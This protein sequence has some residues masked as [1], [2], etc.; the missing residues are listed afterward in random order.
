MNTFRQLSIM[1]FALMCLALFALPVEATEITVASQQVTG[2]QVSASTVKLRIYASESFITSDDKII[3]GGAPPSGKFYKELTCTVAGGVITIPQFV[4]DSTTDNRSHVVPTYTA[5]FFN[6]SGQQIAPYQ[7]F[8]GFRVSSTCDTGTNC[9]WVQIGLFNTATVPIVP[10]FSTYDAATIDRKIAAINGFSNP[11]TTEGDLIRGGAGG[12][13]MRLGIGTDGQFLTVSSGLPAWATL[14]ALTSLNGLTA[15]TQLFA[16]GGNFP[17]LTITSSVATHTFNWTGQLAVPRGGTGLSTILTGEIIYGSATDVYS[18]LAAAA[19]GNAL[20][21]GTTPSWG[22]VGLTT[23]VSGTLP[24]TSGGT[25]LTSYA[26]GDIIIASA[27]N[28]LAALA[29]ASSGNALLSGTTPSWG[30]IGLTTH[31]SGIL[32]SAN[33]GSGMAFF[34]V[35]GPTVLRTFAF[36]DANAT[37][38]T[39]N[40]VVTGLQGGTGFGSYSVGDLLYA[41]TTTTFAKRVIGAAGTVLRSNGTLPVYGQVVLTTD[42]TGVL[43]WANGG[44]GASS[45]AAGYLKSN[46]TSISSQAVPIPIADGGTNAVT[47]ATANG[48]GYFDGTRLV[49]TALGASGTV[50][51]GT[52]A[53][54]QFSN[55]PTITGLTISGLTLGSIPFAGTAG[56]ISQNNA[57]LFWDNTNFRFQLQGEQRFLG[58]SSGYTGVIAAGTTTS[59]TITLPSAAPVSNGLCFKA[60][61]DG[62]ASWGDCVAAGTGITTLNT[63]TASTQVFAVGSSGTDFNISS[64]TATHTFNI[65]SAG[66]GITRG[67]L[68]NTTQT[69]VGVKTLNDTLILDAGTTTDA[70]AKF[71]SSALLSS[72]QAN[73]I[74]WDDS[75]LYLTQNS[76]VVRKTVAYTDSNITGSAAS[77]SGNLTGDVTSVGM[78]TSYNSVVPLAKGGL[79]TSIALGAAGTFLGSDGVSIVFSSNGASLT[80]LNANNISSGILDN[81]RLSG[82][83]LTANK[84]AASGYA[85]LTASTKLNLAQMQEVMASTDLTDFTAKN[86]SGTTILGTTITAP[87]DGEILTY[88]AGNWVNTAAGAAAAHDLLSATHTDTLAAAVSE[89]SILIGNA[90]P[91]WSE[92]VIGSSGTLLRSNGTTAAWSLLALATD[93]SGTLALTNGGTGSSYASVTA[94]FNGIS[95]LTTKGDLIVRDASNA[96]R[97]GIGSNGNA[98]IADSAQANGLKWGAIDLTSSAAVSGILGATNGGT[99]N[100]FF[101]VSGP[102]TS[103]KTYTF[104]NANS[105]MV[106]EDSTN[107]LTNKT[108][109]VES[110]GNTITIVKE[111]WIVAARNAS[112]S[113]NL[114]W[115]VPSSNPATVNGATQANGVSVGWLDYSASATNDGQFQYRL[116]S[117]FTG[118]ID[119]D[120]VWS[121]SNT[122]TGNVRWSIS[123]ACGTGG[124]PTFN[125]ASAQSIAGN[126][127]TDQ[128]NVTTFSSIDSTGCAA[129]DM[130]Y[131]RVQR[132]GADGADTH[133]GVAQVKGATFRYRMVQ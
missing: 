17:N 103:I 67:L 5:I 53:A 90:T 122:N 27:A 113:S 20:L 40:A 106:S 4:I 2:F 23:H 47:F 97:Q 126:G 130:L 57:R 59:Y 39:T 21:S 24:T 15:S 8:V 73:A 117:S 105:T 22:K 32:P 34:A 127:V 56:V 115:N 128:D 116:P 42:V 58:S 118:A 114:V 14:T 3:Q 41:D 81:A 46:G 112:V 60:N 38:L 7:P 89:G 71:Q 9:T 45:F 96:V 11:M 82:V 19:S 85:G 75:F 87:V 133:T 18:R 83:E 50:L 49:V 132:L 12:T 108:L 70:P 88:Q 91:K 28:T 99:A 76:P 35:S 121:S 78:V 80:S 69:I 43:P 93:V 52:G 64:V 107:T 44:T 33:G 25:N 30:K 13:A 31:V 129:G 124:N 104:P 92:L 36:P 98:L 131:M 66:V 123:C 16:V 79:G 125:A 10:P 51:I 68:T 29:A 26:Q 63:L 65:P 110:T 74:E 55:S 100:A 62:T 37:V 6:T 48:V 101:A 119:L 54:P 102:A 120:L 77:I 94:L 84:D 95:P 72:P 109:N 111:D 1:V 86:G 61:T